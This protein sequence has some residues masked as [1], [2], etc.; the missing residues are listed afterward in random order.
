MS[1]YQKKE[2]AAG[3]VWRYQYT[4]PTTGERKSLTAPS[5]AELEYARRKL[6]EARSM[7]AV[8]IS[9]EVAR[10]GLPGR[11]DPARLSVGD[12]WAQWLDTLEPK[13]RRKAESYGRRN[14]DI[15]IR[16]PG[17]GRVSLFALP[18][19][20]L[21]EPTCIAWRSAARESGGMRGQGRSWHTIRTAFDLLGAAVRSVGVKPP[22]WG[23][24]RPVRGA[25]KDVQKVRGERPAVTS[26]EQAQALIAAAGDEDEPRLKRGTYSDRGP[27]C[28][29]ALATG[30]RNAELAGLAWDDFGDLDAASVVLHVRHQATKGWDR[31]PGAS[32]RPLDP[33]KGTEGRDTSR[34]QIVEPIAVL[35]LRA[36]RAEQQ[37]RGWWRPEGPVFGA[38]RGGR[39]RWRT[40][41]YAIDPAELRRWVTAAGIPEPD[42]W[43]THCLRGSFVTLLG[44][45]TNDPRY[46]QERTGHHD[47]STTMGYWR[48]L[49]AGL[50]PPTMGAR[51]GPAPVLGIVAGATEARERARELGP[52]P[53]ERPELEPDPWGI[54][55]PPPSITEA[56]EAAI[57]A[58]QVARRHRAA[59]VTANRSF[60]ELAGEWLRGIGT[61]SPA[62][63][64]LPRPAEV[65]AVARKAAVIAYQK[66]KNAGDGPTVARAA[67]GKSYRA[68][69]AR[70]GRELAD[71]RRRRQ[72]DADARKPAAE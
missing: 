9:P 28:L 64:V 39:W 34:R 46:V 70:W 1:K 5:V 65:T 29:V 67:W 2:T 61:R 25:S 56:T 17:G 11:S 19:C 21:T 58:A 24:W 59:V 7:V 62:G 47:L 55:P 13:P 57:G 15:M 63:R 31:A 20:E 14:V 53:V 38:S 50:P 43:V 49:G 72:A 16:R 68:T 41:G 66:A 48:R 30:L 45:S 54:A 4:D 40:S 32:S 26:W 37:R 6:R 22:P 18:V 60:A 44:A 33:P 35:T 23:S 71:A 69:L 12:C 42:R 10:A 52:A 27:R 8:G 3:T 36:L 51:L